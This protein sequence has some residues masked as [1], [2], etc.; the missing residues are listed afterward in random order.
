MQV[1]TRLRIST[2][3]TAMT[4]FV[5]VGMLSLALY[6]IIDAVE[7]SAITDDIIAGA[8]ERLALRNDYVHNENERA[9]VQWDAKH[10]RIGGLLHAASKRFR[11]PRYKKTIDEMI[12]NHES[13]GKLFAGIVENREKMRR[14][15]I[16][17]GLARETE[18]RLISQ[19][20][21][22]V[23]AVIVLGNRLLESSRES[24]F[25]ALRLAGWGIFLALV[26]LLAVSITNL[27]I[28]GR[29]ITDR[30]RRLHDGALEIGRGNLDHRID[31]RGDDEFAGLSDA[32]NSMTA[33]LKTSYRNLETE[34]EERKRAEADILKLSEDMAARNV[35]LEY[36]NRELES[37]VYSVSHDLR[38]PLRSIMGFTKIVME[39]YA[40]TLDAQGRDYLDRIARGSARMS[41]LIDALLDLS[42]I[43]RQEVQRTDVDL[44]AMAGSIISE[45]REA[46]PDRQV[47]VRIGEGVSAFADRRLIELVLSNLLD[48]AWKFTARSGSARIEFGADE[49]DGPTVYYVRDNG[50]GFDQ[51]YAEKMFLPFHRL[52][53]DSE[54][55]GTGIGLSIVERIV[56]RHG[57][58]IWAEGAAGGGA[59]VYFTVS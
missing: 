48:N 11:E 30:V 55:E 35:E 27:R 18:D 3:I 53:S 47:D 58:R 9:R 59:V 46:H 31:V 22:R 23:Y 24:L 14:R 19:L 56:R 51:E 38:A 15:A 17:T 4:V 41:H 52:H 40:G 33:K 20:N 25:A 36:A 54:Y 39:D 43:S 6:R 37:F 16:P 28:M 50:V 8:L 13:I 2:V 45:L 26:V 44:S 34:V 42:R 12:R 1:K 57:G 7:G 29:A 49:K 21:M 10:E 5:I 32:F